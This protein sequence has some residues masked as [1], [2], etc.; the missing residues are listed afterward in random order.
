MIAGYNKERA[1]F[2]DNFVRDN[3]FDK[4][5]FPY[6]SNANFG[7]F[8]SQLPRVK[9]GTL[10]DALPTSIDCPVN[11]TMQLIKAAS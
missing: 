4:D 1:D 6:T 8:V 2:K 3:D 11:G 7:L 9:S 10:T 5:I